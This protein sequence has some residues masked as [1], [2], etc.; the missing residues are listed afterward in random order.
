MTTRVYPIYPH[1][2]V[3]ALALAGCQHSHSVMSHSELFVLCNVSICSSFREI[4]PAFALDVFGPT[5]VPTY[6]CTHISLQVPP[7]TQACPPWRW[8]DWSFRV[9]TYSAHYTARRKCK[10]FQFEFSLSK[11]TRVDIPDLWIYDVLREDGHCF[12][13]ISGLAPSNH[14][15]VVCPSSRA[16]VWPSANP[17]VSR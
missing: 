14:F 6:M 5:L 11:P 16:Y 10:W 4:F 8:W 12:T 3:P 17:S 2:Q 15:F 7:R 9:S 13:C 1:W